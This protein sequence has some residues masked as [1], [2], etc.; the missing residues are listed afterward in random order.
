MNFIDIFIII[1]LCF[2]LIVGWKNG[3]T[4]QLVS[5][6]GFIL[7]I[8]LAYCL[9]GFVASIF[10]KSM[11]FFNFNGI[12]VINIIFYEFLAFLITLSVLVFLVKI[13]LKA[14]S[15]FEKILNVT[16]VLG[17]PSHIL[18]AIIGAIEY[19]VITFI[20]I[21]FFNLP[22]FNFSVVRDCKFTKTFLDKK[23]I[24]NTVCEDTLELYNK[25][26]ELK[27]K[28]QNETDKSKVNIEILQLLR[29][30]KMIS[31][32]DVDYL[33]SHGKLENVDIEV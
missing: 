19:F 14:S 27:E 18:G 15:L 13:L 29:Q 2:G 16:I 26:N 28:A 33:I 3:F 30:Y 9:K 25:V 22:V 1:F 32:N 12:T 20:I 23:N 8:V 24:L 4:R 10:F 21:F 31:Q 11:P 7:A 6:I 5:S 17:V